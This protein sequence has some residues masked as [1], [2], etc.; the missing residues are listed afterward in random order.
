[1]PVFFQPFACL[2][3]LL[4]VFLCTLACL[5]RPLCLLLQLLH[6]FVQYIIMPVF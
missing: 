3:L 2:L 6:V 1:L 4:S 5:F